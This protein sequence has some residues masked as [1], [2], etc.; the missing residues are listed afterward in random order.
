[1]PDL[2]WNTIHASAFSQMHGL[3]RR[4]RA[5]ARPHGA[6]RYRCPL[7]GAYVLVTDEPT[8]KRLSRPPARIRCADCGEQH[9]MTIEADE[10]AEIV[11][12]AGKA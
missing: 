6:I 2:R 1:M 11:A 10:A 8:L 9:L 5:T 12:A 3:L 4:T 7:T